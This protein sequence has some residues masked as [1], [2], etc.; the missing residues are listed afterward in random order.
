MTAL[1]EAELTA[2]AQ[3]YSAPA[4]ALVALVDRLGVVLPKRMRAD[5]LVVPISLSASQL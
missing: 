5:D 3:R 1:T 4:E 2:G